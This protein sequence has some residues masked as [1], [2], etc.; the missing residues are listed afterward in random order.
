CFVDANARTVCL[1]PRV[2]LLK[3]LALGIFDEPYRRGSPAG[4]H[5]KRVIIRIGPSVYK[6][7][8]KALTREIKAFSNFKPFP[9]SI[10]VP[11]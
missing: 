10:L 3:L 1:T 2:N 4:T 5:P 7:V 6:L 9:T 8:E 11:L